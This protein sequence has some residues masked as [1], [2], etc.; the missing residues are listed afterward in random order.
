MTKP[1]TRSPEIVRCEFRYAQ[2]LRVF[3]HNV[4]DHFLRNLR[5]PDNTFAPNASENLTV[6]DLR[7]S[8]PVV[9]RLLHPTGHRNRADVSSFA[10]EVN[11]GPMVFAA[12]NMVKGQIN[13]L[14][15]TKPTP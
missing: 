7:N 4:P 13:N 2:L 14:C 3:L 9:N 8:Q 5:S 12:L 10:N 6:R 15:S 1:G 11:Y